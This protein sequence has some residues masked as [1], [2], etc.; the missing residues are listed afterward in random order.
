MVPFMCLF[1]ICLKKIVVL[2]KL[3]LLMNNII[4]ALNKCFFLSL[5]SL[6]NATF[7]PKYFQSKWSSFKFDVHSQS[8][9]ICAFT[10]NSDQQSIIGILLYFVTEIILHLLTLLLSANI[11]H[12]NFLQKFFYKH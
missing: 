5:N 8:K 12:F 3:T 4:N 9:F 1:L 2:R 10:Q 7:L 6:A 11:I